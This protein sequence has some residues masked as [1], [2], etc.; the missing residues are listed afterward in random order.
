MFKKGEPKCTGEK[1]CKSNKLS[2][3]TSGKGRERKGCSRPDNNEVRREG[4]KR[5]VLEDRFSRGEVERLRGKG[6]RR[7]EYKKLETRMPS[8]TKNVQRKGSTPDR[9]GRRRSSKKRG[10][11][12]KGTARGGRKGTDHRVVWEPPRMLQ[13]G[14]GKS[15]RS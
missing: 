3:S 1:S 8:M 9:G 15:T 12:T 6:G 4:V 11:G 7:K 13:D 5:D 10:Y 14:E 2:L